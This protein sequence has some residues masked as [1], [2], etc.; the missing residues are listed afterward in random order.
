MSWFMT[1]GK[2]SLHA[3]FSRTSYH[4]NISGLPFTKRM[5]DKS[6]ESVTKKIDSLL[7]KNG[8]RAEGLP[9]GDELYR[10]SLAEKGFVGKEFLSSSAKKSIYFNEPCSL[11]VAIGGKDL[12][13]IT[14]LLSGLAVSDT[15]NIASGAEELLDGELEFAYSEESGYYSAIPA[16]CGSGAVFS[17][18]LFLPGVKMS[19][20]IASLRALCADGGALLEPAFIYPDNCGDLYSL[21]LSP[22][23]LSNENTA[24]ESF[25]ALAEGIIDR[26]NSIERMIFEENA[27]ILIDNAWRAYAQL[28]YARRLD[29]RDLLSLS[30]SVRFALCA[31]GDNAKLPP[32]GVK[33]LNYLLG[34]GL[35]ASVALSRPGIGN[36]DE[37]AEARAETV[38]K[39]IYTASG[40]PM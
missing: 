11:S 13:S 28:L 38:S 32:V 39:L 30:S 20:E 5:G 19:G 18:M 14:S 8:F 34:E 15:R 31:A 4:R 17:V 10:L 37:I 33:D 21:S 12:I 2:S 3:I 6:L 23:H 27:K 36:D 16:L 7:T 24:A 26:E 25:S 1:E 29:E 22:S 9:D 40:S 35:N